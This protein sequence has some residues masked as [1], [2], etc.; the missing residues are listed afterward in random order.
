MSRS[1]ESL[2]FRRCSAWVQVRFTYAGSQSPISWKLYAIAAFT[3][4]HLIHSVSCSQNGKG[5]AP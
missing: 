3:V 5:W 4:S 2:P 1:F